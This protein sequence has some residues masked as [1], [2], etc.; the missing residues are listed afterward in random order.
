MIKRYSTALFGAFTITFFLFLGMHFL[1]VPEEA[2][3]PLIKSHG[4]AII[5]KTRDPELP[6]KKITKPEK[7]IDIIEP[8]A[9]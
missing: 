5:G 2:E 6:L 9:W 1:I 3:K 8:I 7:I 4:P